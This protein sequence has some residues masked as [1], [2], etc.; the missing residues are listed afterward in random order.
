MKESISLPPFKFKK[1]VNET[2]EDS[3]LF[4]YF[5]ETSFLFVVF[6]KQGNTYTLK[7]CQLWNMPYTDYATMEE[8]WNAIRNTIINGVVL[9][10]SQDKSGKIILKN[11]FPKKSNNRIIH[12]RPHAQKGAYYF[13]NQN[14]INNQNT[15][16]NI[17][18]DANELPDG[19]YMTTQS[20]WLN[21]SYVLSQLNSDFLK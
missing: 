15:I 8:G 4:N 1:L 11:N 14:I 13:P 5:N 12:I 10:P 21:N 16:G 17:S 18:R 3:D 2:W 6:K 7:G 19:R 9:K 20:F